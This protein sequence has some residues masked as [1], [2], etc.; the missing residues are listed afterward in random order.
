MQAETSRLKDETLALKAEEKDL[1]LALRGGA[2]Q[3]SLP[4]LRNNVSELEA[5]KTELSTRLAGLKAGSFKP[6]SL[7][8]R[9]KAEGLARKIE[10]DCKARLKIRNELWAE[11]ASHFE[12]EKAEEVKEE[13]GLE[14]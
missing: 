2:T 13:L 11:I 5:K 7:E 6:V 4:E 12:K 1:R 9:E 14:F 10:R 8:E 3:V